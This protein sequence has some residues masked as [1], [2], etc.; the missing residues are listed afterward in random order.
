MS[1]HPETERLAQLVEESPTSEEA[2]HLEACARCRAELE[3]LRVQ[4]RALRELPDLEAPGGEWVTLAE[5]LRAEGLLREAPRGKRPAS[6]SGGAR[7]GGAG[8]ASLPWPHG[9]VQGAGDPGLPSLG[10]DGGGVWDPGPPS[11]RGAAH[12]F[13]PVWRAAAALALFV[14]GGLA[15]AWIRGAPDPASAERSTTSPAALASTSAPASAEDAARLLQA[16]E[17]AYLTAMAGYLEL[18][19]PEEVPDPLAR[20]AALETIVHTTRAALNQAPADPLI[21]GYHFTALAQ[22]DAMIEQLASLAGSWF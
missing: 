22:R 16:A 13:P 3:A 5:R 15:G 6:L 17:A 11:R 12:R 4:T 20:L 21:N 7:P 18:A 9:G 1:H 2:A 14:L 8:D 10:S 19:E